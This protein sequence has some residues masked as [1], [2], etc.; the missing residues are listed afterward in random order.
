M[1]AQAAAKGSLSKA[2]DKASENHPDYKGSL[3]INEDLPAGTK[4]WLSAWLNQGDNGMYMSIKASVAEDR[5]PR[6][7]GV[8]RPGRSNYQPQ[9][10][11]PQQQPQRQFGGPNF[12]NSGGMDDEIPF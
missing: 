3:T 7:V 5:P 4:L 9:R 8:Q 6:Q 11:Q 12:A 1:T 10:Q 2:K